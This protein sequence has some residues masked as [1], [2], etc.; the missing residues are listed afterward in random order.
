MLVA[1]RQLGFVLLVAS[2][3]RVCARSLRT[4][5]RFSSKGVVSSSA[6]IVASCSQAKSIQDT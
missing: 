6:V 5:V 4:A 3:Y 1:V 2:C